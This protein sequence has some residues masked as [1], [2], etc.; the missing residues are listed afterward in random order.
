VLRSRARLFEHAQRLSLAYHDRIGTA[1]SLYRIHEDSVP[2]HYVAVSGL[3]PIVTSV[4]VLAGLLGV[5]AWID[6]ELRAIA[7]IVVPVLVALTEYYRRR[8]RAGWS[9]LRALGRLR[10]LRG[11]GGARCLARREGVRPRGARERALS[12]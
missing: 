8:V 10:R 9:E 3:V 7:L 4:C 11:A 6:A 12:R 5:T 1:D 2:A